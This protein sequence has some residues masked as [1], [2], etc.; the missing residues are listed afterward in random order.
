VSNA[1]IYVFSPKSFK[2]EDVGKFLDTLD[3]IQT[4]FYSMPNSVFIIGTVP[5]KTLSKLLVNKF[6]QHR[7]Y[8]GLLSKTAR[9]GWMPKDHW[10]LLPSEKKA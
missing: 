8:V 5:A 3:G 6:G 4:W 9:A 10:A 2:Q 1:Y 7:H